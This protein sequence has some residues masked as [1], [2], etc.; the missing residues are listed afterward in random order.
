M[1]YNYRV[2]TGES[3][4]ETRRCGLC[5][6][7]KPLTEFHRRGDRYQSWC[8]SCRKTYD[9]G[10][11]AGRRE[12]R[13]TQKRERIARL[14]EWMRQAKSKPCADCGG[15]FHPAA[16]Q[17]DHLPGILKRLDVATLVRRGSIGLARA[18]IAKCEIVCANC[19]AMRTF[20]RRE[21]AREDAGVD[22]SPQ[23]GNAT[24]MSRNRLMAAS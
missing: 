6:A 1:F 18:E 12:L 16:M 24:S 19:H 5:F 21:R 10:Y 2:T 11:H 13:M 8:K 9:A 17:F 23:S 14:I 7:S 22:T 20:M 4:G 15:R 3:A